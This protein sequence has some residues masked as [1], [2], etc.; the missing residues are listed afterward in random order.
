[1]ENGESPSNAE[2]PG[3]EVLV[4]TDKNLSYQQDLA[5]RN[6]AIVVLGQG[7]WNL[8]QSL[9]TPFF[10]QDIQGLRGLAVFAVVLFHA[11]S[12][13]LRGGFVGVDMF[14]VISGYVI[15]GLIRRDLMEG[16]FSC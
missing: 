15:G 13:L 4:T 2:G 12:S 11:S 8:M 5:G 14:F 9:K 7:R 1:M 16:R 10:R 6:I 3:F